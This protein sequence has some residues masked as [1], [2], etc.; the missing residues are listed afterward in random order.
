[1]QRRHYSSCNHEISIIVGVGGPRS[2]HEMQKGRYDG[3]LQPYQTSTPVN[4][5]DIENALDSNVERLAS[6][7]I[8]LYLS[9]R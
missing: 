7:A 6:S 5:K 2:L 4:M 3:E 1:M 8:L 9:A